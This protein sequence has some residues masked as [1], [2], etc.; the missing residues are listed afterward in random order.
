LKPDPAVMKR[1]A[2]IKNPHHVSVELLA[3]CDIARRDGAVLKFNHSAM[4]RYRIGP[5]LLP[6][7][8]NDDLGILKS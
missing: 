8:L 6:V 1:L 4:T 3:I 2:T 7:A 5:V